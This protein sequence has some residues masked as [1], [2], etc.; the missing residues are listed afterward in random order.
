MSSSIRL[1]DPEH[2]R[3]QRPR[4]DENMAK[5]K[6]PGTEFFRQIYPVNGSGLDPLDA[7]INGFLRLLIAL[8]T[9]PSFEDFLKK[10]C[11]GDCLRRIS[12]PDFQ[13]FNATLELQPDGTWQY[14][15]VTRL[16]FRIDCVKPVF[17]SNDEL[18]SDILA[19]LE[20]RK[21]SGKGKK[22]DRA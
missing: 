8:L 5:V 3:L 14:L 15:I 1:D 17:I 4:E 7:I 13:N 20:R 18:T 6:C 10:E 19:R 21:K 22:K 9:T 2:V 16:E 11:D 12:G